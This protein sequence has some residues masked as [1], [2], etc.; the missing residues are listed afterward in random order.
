[1]WVDVGY[2]SIWLK[3]AEMCP[4]GQVLIHVQTMAMAL[5]LASAIKSLAL[6]TR[7]QS[8]LTK[9][10]IVAPKIHVRS[11]LTKPEVVFLK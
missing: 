9:G 5:A 6:I 11:A 3:E 2:A 7:G 1:M 4:R 10:R 8:N